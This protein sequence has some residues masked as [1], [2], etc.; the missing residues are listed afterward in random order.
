METTINS[1]EYVG[2]TE[3]ENTT[4]VGVKF[5]AST[6][7]DA[8]LV[9]FSV[10]DVKKHPL[11]FK[12]EAISNRVEEYGLADNLHA[13]EALVREVV[14]GWYHLEP[15]GESRPEINGG[16]DRRITIKWGTGAKKAARSILSQHED[17]LKR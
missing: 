7:V 15:Q 13:I 14:F 2:T 4:P 17:R 8:I 5:T 16:V 1:I 11:W 12:P 6:D 9:Y 3:T 10:A